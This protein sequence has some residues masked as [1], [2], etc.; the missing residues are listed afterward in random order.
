LATAILAT[1][2]VGCAGAHDPTVSHPSQPS[3][4][5][6][7]SGPSSREIGWTRVDVDG[8]LRSITHMEP[9]LAAGERD[10]EALLVEVLDGVAQE[11]TV[12]VSNGHPHGLALVTAYAANAAVTEAVGAEN[13][14]PASLVAG[15]LQDGELD[16][17]AD[18]LRTAERWDL[19]S[20]P[21]GLTD[22][23]SWDLGWWVAGHKDLRPVVYDFD[24][25]DGANMAVPDT[26]LD[27]R[28]PAVYVARAPILAPMVLATQ[29]RDGP[30]VWLRGKRRSWTRIP[31]P[32]GRLTAAE[33]NGDGIYVLVD[34]VLWYR[35]LPARYLPP[36]RKATTERRQ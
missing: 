28:H 20:Q 8:S 26:W 9:F 5:S 35:P 36:T 3:Q 31:A 23:A 18:V 29:S 19:A 21:D 15:S 27:P 12:P 24:A 17:E 32:P 6:Q 4:P 10:G 25:S 11:I 34:G 1:A 22:L 30:T 2:L 7:P 14:V 16:G 33:Q 13:T